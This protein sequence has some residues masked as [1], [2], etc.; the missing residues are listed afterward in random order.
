MLKL[1][2]Y[3]E[4]IIPLSEQ[5]FEQILDLINED[6]KQI[7]PD[8]IDKR[9]NHFITLTLVDDELIKKIN[10]KYRGLNEPTDVVSL[11]YLDTDAFPGQDMIGEI[12]ISY[13]TAERQAKENEMELL[14]E[15]K[16]L[17]VHGLL[18]ILGYEHSCEA[19]FQTMMN[20]TNEILAIQG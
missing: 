17:F 12:F 10:N 18:H 9:K 19:D 13:E 15:I 2:Y 3:N 16:F 20:L 5:V 8:S 14:D 4:T 6:Y 1:E 7:F 11:T